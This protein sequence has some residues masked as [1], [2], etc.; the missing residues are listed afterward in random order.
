MAK[1]E[2][3]ELQNRTLVRLRRCD[4]WSE[5]ERADGYV[6][7]QGVRPNGKVL[8]DEF[9]EKVLADLLKVGAV[10]CDASQRIR[11]EPWRGTASKEI[12]V[13]YWRAL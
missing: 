4:R 1:S 6:H 13:K 3:T 5:D 10:E 11:Q 2:L 8:S 9:D 7:L 12:T